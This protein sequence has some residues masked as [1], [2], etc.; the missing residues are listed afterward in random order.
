MFGNLG[1]VLKLTYANFR[2]DPK[3]KESNQLKYMILGTTLFW[4]DIND[5]FIIVKIKWK[6]FTN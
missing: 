3:L 4:C 5:I 1:S 2:T 6:G